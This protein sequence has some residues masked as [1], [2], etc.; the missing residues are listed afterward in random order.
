MLELETLRLAAWANEVGG[1]ERLPEIMGLEIIPFSPELRAHEF[2]V[3]LLQHV[4]PRWVERAGG[5]DS[6]AV[7]IFNEKVSPIVGVRIN[8]DGTASKIDE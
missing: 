2:N 6:E 5:A 7:R 3:A 8:P 1:I 4:L